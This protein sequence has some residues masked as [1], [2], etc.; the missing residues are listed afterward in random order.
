MQGA[1]FSYRGVCRGFVT[2]Q[3][4][5]LSESCLQHFGGWA[6]R[7]SSLECFHFTALWGLAGPRQD[8]CCGKPS[9]V[10]V[11][12]HSSLSVPEVF[13]VWA[14][15]HQQL[16][17]AREV[18]GRDFCSALLLCHFWQLVKG[19]LCCAEGWDVGL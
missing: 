19:V 7:Q 6:K 8:C 11:E 17:T 5:L 10:L 13:V 18:P 15:L 3:G 1:A 14:A 12:R 4:F 2:C 16:G 9:C